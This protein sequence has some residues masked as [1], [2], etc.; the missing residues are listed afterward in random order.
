M[1]RSNLNQP[2]R[3]RRTKIMIHE[4]LLIQF[5][6]CRLTR[7]DESFYCLWSANTYFGNISKVQKKKKKKQKGKKKERIKHCATVPYLFF[8]LNLFMQVGS[9]II[10]L[11]I[12]NCAFFCNKSVTKSMLV[13]TAFK[14]V[15]IFQYHQTCNEG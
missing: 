4:A 10:I 14:F 8:F 7:C 11:Y 15:S 12:E 5:N 2:H 1:Y 6:S 9:S 3:I 13:L